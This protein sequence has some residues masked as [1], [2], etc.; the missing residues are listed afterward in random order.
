MTSYDTK[1]YQ[2]IHIKTV[3]LY[4]FNLNTSL[5][6]ADRPSWRNNQ[7]N[8]EKSRSWKIKTNSLLQSYIVRSVA[9]T[10]ELKKNKPVA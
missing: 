4:E 3:M 8:L 2:I 9:L 5:N 6:Y 7:T 10:Q 1:Y